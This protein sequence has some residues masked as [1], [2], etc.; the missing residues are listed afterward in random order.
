MD[1]TKEMGLLDREPYLLLFMKV[2]IS[3]FQPAQGQ[4]AHHPGMHPVA[5]IPRQPGATLI[6]AP[7]PQPIQMT[8][9]S[10]PHIS[11]VSLFIKFWLLYPICGL[12]PILN[13]TH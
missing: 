4:Q 2:H 11:M 7:G 10:S 6:Y 5:Q 3:S 12:T 1:L 13:K 9:H 8:I